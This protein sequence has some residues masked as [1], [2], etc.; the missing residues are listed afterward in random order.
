MLDFRGL[1]ENAL[2]ALE[3]ERPADAEK[4]IRAALAISPRDDQLLHLLGVTLIRQQREPEAI[5][6]LKKAISLNRRDAEYHNAL[7][8]ALRNAG[9]VAEGMESLRRAIKLEPELL[10]AH[11]NLGQALQRVGELAKA[12]ETFRWLLARKPGDVEVMGALSNLR[13]FTGDR[14]SAIAILRQGIVDNPSTG[15]MRFFLSEQLLALGEFQ[16]G[17]LRYLWRVNRFSF[18][19]RCGR[20]VDDPVLLAPLPAS[21]EG[22]TIKVHAE[23]GIGDDIFFL[24]FV[25][26]LRER[27]A[28]VSAAVTPRLV[29]MVHR[30]GAL[31][32]VNPTPERIPPSL[33]YLLLGDLPHLLQSHLSE[34]PPP[35]R[36]EALP[37][38]RAAALDVLQGFPKP[39]L[40]LTWRAGTGP[41]AGNRNALFKEVPFDKFARFAQ[42][43]PGTLVVL[44][45]Q[46]KDGEVEQ[47][48]ALCGER[49]LDMA[50]ANEDLERMHGLLEA[51]D[52]YIGVSNTNMHL[53][54][55]LG[56]TARVLVSANAE[57]RW[58]ATGNRSPWF[59]GFSVYRQG[60]DGDWNVAFEA[61]R[62]DLNH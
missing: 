62:N 51:L 48:R 6:P 24:R 21:L 32:E 40:G 1:I 17:W 16:E 4:G 49:V 5:E 29:S 60:T 18:L 10:D 30:S 52:D 14:D 57:F 25:S 27:G 13:W 39:W 43:L 9:H 61:V 53:C 7:G 38:H 41:E 35:L 45:R 54:A 59:P 58:M 26:A 20:Q 19:R 28:R 36:F 34:V 37:D 50:A 33:E 15:D 11:F 55:A 44:Q 2:R 8:C 47:L 22:R 12:D 3:E 23:Q 42:S 56:R 31:D 46:P